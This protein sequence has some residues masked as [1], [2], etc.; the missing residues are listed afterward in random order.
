M[1][2]LLG[3]IADDFT[4]GTDLAGQLVKAV[5]ASLRPSSSVPTM[6]PGPSKK[7]RSVRENRWARLQLGMEGRPVIPQIS[8]QDRRDD[9]IECFR[10]Q[11][12]AS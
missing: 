4:G 1:N 3:C 6:N 11:P 8:S 10:G 9:R 7:T 12:K 5:T 2:L